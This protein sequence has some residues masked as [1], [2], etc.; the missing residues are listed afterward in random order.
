MFFFHDIT[1][2]ARLTQDKI[3]Q[4][5]EEMRA[6]IEQ[7]KKDIVDAKSRQTEASKDIKR[8]E[9][10][11]SE[12]N[13]N[14]DSKLEELQTTLD[15]LKKSLLKNSSSVKELQKEL[16]TSRLDSEQVGSDLSAAEEQLVES[17]NT[18]KAQIEEIESQKREQARLKVCNVLS[19]L[20]DDL[21]ADYCRMPMTSRKLNL[22]MSGPS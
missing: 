14:K 12:F 21:L 13:N 22:M 2:N 17:D 8:I 6:N 19:T 9:K 1:R 4:A 10:D 18:L 20:L 7:L 11:M 5:V 15:K 16:Q 3:I